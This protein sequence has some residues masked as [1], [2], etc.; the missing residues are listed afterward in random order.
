M[1]QRVLVFERDPD[2]IREL[3]EQF[4]AMGAEV[5]AV[6]DVEAGLSRAK[7]RD[8]AL[9]L[10][11]MDA[12]D[13]PGEGFLVCKRFKSDDQLAAIPFVI[14]GGAQHAE[15]FESHKKLK[16]RRAD[17]YVTLPV[18]TAE[19]VAQVAPLAGLSADSGHFG[20]SV[21]DVDVEIDDFAENA[22]GEL[23]R[24]DEPEPEPEPAPAPAEAA[25]PSAIPPVSERP[26]VPDPEA[27]IARLRDALS[28]ATRRAEGAEE[29]WQAAEQR[30]VQADERGKEAANRAD[31]AERK[32]RD[33]LRPSAP[34]AGGP[35]KMTSRDYLDLRE[36]LN[37]KDKE[38]LALRDEITLRDRQILDAN[39][40]TLEL[41][42]AQAELT[43]GLAVTQRDLEE[44]NS[45]IRAYEV[46]REA[47]NKRLEELR[48]R[49]TRA[50]E[51]SKRLEDDLEAARALHARELEELRASH[52]HVLSERARLTTLEI[53]RVRAEHI[54]KLEELTALQQK[55][56]ADA[57]VGRE[58][59]VASLRSS[60]ERTLFETRAAHDAELEERR[61]ASE[62]ALQSAIADA[63]A[64]K[65]RALDLLA[66]E[67]AQE[68]DRKLA[69]AERA[70]IAAL[71]TLERELETRHTA[72]RREAE[73]RHATEVNGLQRRL[74]EAESRGVLLSE[75]VEELETSKQ[76]LD[77]TL[78]A[79][80]RLL[81]GDLAR[82]TEE[83]DTAHNEL[84][85]MRAS[86]ASLER[87]GAQLSER[88]SVLESD[89]AR[90]NHRIDQQNAKIETDKE[91]LE[92]VRRALGIGI[93]L[94]EQ[95]RQNVV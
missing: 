62:S 35:S 70:R 37:R 23:M 74:S 92:R 16:K 85:A 88:L 59:E 32:L 45:K 55:E 95:Q 93:G 12:M 87:N 90:A 21:S 73:E 64:D 40:R 38:L 47:V 80:L 43:D 34:P 66:A 15:S 69:D 27:E 36:Q 76:E 42:R 11:S 29:R 6:R 30:A 94:L 65:A 86:I 41:E 78:S 7:E 18:P 77:R 10:L 3:E 68:L 52:E 58:N 50:D 26:G 84:S 25:A 54:A 8:V 67:R 49:L 71:A 4:G 33:Q 2:F 22:F 61:R 13:A 31:A 19:L 82:R 28:D 91:L 60:Y 56:L 48:A 57:Q 44:A 1:A 9:V 14:M 75:R 89:L 51:K 63:A 83:R 24:T 81:E 53:D 17:E 20:S 39:D 72:E 79:R 46:D 5:E